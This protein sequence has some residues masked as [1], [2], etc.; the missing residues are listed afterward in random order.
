MWFQRLA[1][2]VRLAIIQ[3]RGFYDK[4]SFFQ[5]SVQEKM[6]KIWYFRWRGIIWYCIW[7]VTTI[8]RC[9][10]QQLVGQVQSFYVSL[11]PSRS[12]ARFSSFALLA[13]EIE[14]VLCSVISSIRSQNITW[15]LHRL[16]S[17]LSR[18]TSSWT[19]RTR[20][21]RASLEFERNM[22]IMNTAFHLLHVVMSNVSC[23]ISVKHYDAIL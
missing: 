23:K 13:V 8:G 15:R 14:N 5:Q 22:R 18:N 3:F 12:L 4:S 20:S 16:P 7:C 21:K 17:P 19:I 2:Q 9:T 10:F 11:K 6:T 1:I